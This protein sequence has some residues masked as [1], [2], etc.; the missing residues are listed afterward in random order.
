MVHQTYDSYPGQGPQRGLVPRQERRTALMTT[1]TMTAS[2]GLTGPLN[3]PQTGVQRVV[4]VNTPRAGRPTRRGRFQAWCGDTVRRAIRGVVRYRFELAPLGGMGVLTSLGW[5]QWAEGVGPLGIAA[6]AACGLT[7]AV[8]CGGGMKHKADHITHAGGAAALVFADIAAGV[9]NGPGP[10]SLTTFA[11]T[12]M[13]AYA[14]YGPWLTKVRHE[15]MKLH[16]ETLKAQGAVPNALGIP[17]LDPGLTGYSMEEIA[18]RHAIFALTGCTPLSVVVYPNDLGFRAVVTMPPGKTN[19]PEA[20][21]RKKSQFASNLGMEGALSLEKTGANELTVI[22]AN[23]DILAAGVPYSDDGGRTIRDKIRLG[24]D[25]NG[26]EVFVDLLYRHT[27]IAGASDFGKSS[28][29]NLIIKRLLRRGVDLYGI[30][31][32]PGAVELGPWAPKLKRLARTVDEARDLLDFLQAEMHRR[33]RLLERLTREALREGRKPTRKWDPD[34]HGP[35]IVVITDELAELIRQDEVQ[36]QQEEAERKAAKRG[37]DFDPEMEDDP[38]PPISQQYESLLALAR[39]T[40]IM[41]VSATQQPSRKVFGGSTDAR[42]NYANRISTRTGEAGH[43]QFIFGAGCT[44]RG[45]RPEELTEPGEFLISTT[46]R[47][48]EV[49]IRCRAEHVKD[50]DIADDVMD[51]WNADAEFTVEREDEDEED[52][53]FPG[54]DALTST[55]FYPKVGTGTA[56][57]LTKRPDPLRF[58]DG[59]PVRDF[60]DLYREFVRLCREH[61]STTKAELTDIGPFASRDT[62]RRAFEAWEPHG[63][64]KTKISKTWHYSL[65]DD[66]SGEGDEEE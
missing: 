38:R 24:L 34:T 28:I 16:V 18:L 14:F 64:V 65:P 4:V 25:E 59:T 33:G 60:R 1:T 57:A 26:R 58:P 63:I 54:L 44:A 35:A 50:Q 10:I 15:R 48:H 17:A 7:G 61:G 37:G 6:Y 21:V 20:I 3:G 42:G 32:K 52:V 43:A 23:G 22:L 40:G 31:M 62:V 41:F 30:D 53:E 66:P 45:W 2:G 27:L 46:E 36:R 49:P 51:A 39:A 9:A 55:S 29:V 47:G 8:A 56:V 19:G 11:V 5:W 12:T 13:G